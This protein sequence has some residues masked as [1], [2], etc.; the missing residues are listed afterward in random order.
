MRLYQGKSLQKVVA[1]SFVFLLFIGFVFSVS[2]DV[3]VNILAVNG[4]DEA[5]DREIRQL[6]P[7]ELHLYHRLYRSRS[8]FD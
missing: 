2:A 6:L 7:K 1:F 3:Y 4:T 8:L 5:K